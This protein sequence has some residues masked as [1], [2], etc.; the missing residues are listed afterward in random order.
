MKAIL[1]F[2]E[3]MGIADVE[4][5]V[6]LAG[7]EEPE[8]YEPESLYPARMYLPGTC[9][10]CHMLHPLIYERQGFRLHDDGQIAVYR[11]TRSEER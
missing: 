4:V 5:D 1:T 8:L 2:P 3:D 9:P 11:F 10:D 6:P 7:V